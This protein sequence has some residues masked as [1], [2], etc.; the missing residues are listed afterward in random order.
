MNKK[1]N[2]TKEYLEEEY[3]KKGRS[4]RNIAAELNC[5][6]DTVIRYAKEYNLPIKTRPK[7]FDDLTGRVFQK[8]TVIK[9]LGKN[10]N[11]KYNNWLCKCECGTELERFDVYLFDN[12]KNACFQCRYADQSITNWQGYKEISLTT[13]TT[14]KVGAKN[15]N[16]EFNITIE[17]AWELFLKQNRK[18]AITGIDLQFSRNTKKDKSQTASLDRIDNTKGY[19]EGNVQWVHKKINYIKHAM[20]MEEL[21]KWANLISDYNKKKEKK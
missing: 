3:I 6:G 13:W 2:I 15:R 11:K 17:Y 8:L 19:I 9:Y 16:R 14:I 5:T 7:P 21:I 20:T 18:C 10:S 4:A 1:F 12:I